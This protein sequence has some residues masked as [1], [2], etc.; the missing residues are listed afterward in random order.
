M[1][2]GYFIADAINTEHVVVFEEA[3][4]NTEGI[5]AYV[6]PGAVQFTDEE[7]GNEKIF[8]F[9]VALDKVSVM[10]IFQTEA[11]RIDEKIGEFIASDLCAGDLGS[12]KNRL[13]K[14]ITIEVNGMQ[15]IKSWKF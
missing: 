7:S 13:K 9:P 1:G 2:M 15:Q 3:V 14:A 11:N 6:L 8:Y 12:H 10:P 5:K 4:C